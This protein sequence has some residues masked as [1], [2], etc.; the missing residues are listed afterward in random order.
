MNQEDPSTWSSLFP[1]TDEDFSN[2]LELDGLD[3]DF[4]AFDSSNEQGNE[5]KDPYGG[6]VGLDGGEPMYGV[7]ATG[8]KMPPSDTSLSR[9]QGSAVQAPQRGYQQHGGNPHHTQNTIHSHGNVPP[10]PTSMELQGGVHG[11]FPVMDSQRAWNMHEVHLRKQQDQVGSLDYADSI[12]THSST[13][14]L[15]PSGFTGSDSTRWSISDA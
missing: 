13:D 14:G 12:R 3:L 10:T 1:N 7:E 5:L 2:L 6:G 11:Q 8:T 15:H 9:G 4:S